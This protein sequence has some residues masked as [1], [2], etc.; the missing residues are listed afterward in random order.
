MIETTLPLAPELWARVP[1]PV[2]A[3]LLEQWVTRRIPYGEGCAPRAECRPARAGTRRG[4]PARLELGEFL[5][6]VVRGSPFA[7][8][9]PNA[10]P[11]GRKRGAQQ[12]F[13]SD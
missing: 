4:S 12:H 6:A 7:P 1:A 3:P 10:L 8:V 2:Q 5:P 13:A 9:H 11:S